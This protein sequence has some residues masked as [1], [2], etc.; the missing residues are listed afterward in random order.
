MTDDASRD[1][2]IIDEVANPWYVRYSPLFIG[3]AVAAGLVAWGR[4]RRKNVSQNPI[5]DRR[6]EYRMEPMP[7]GDRFA[8]T[9][10]DMQW[11]RFLQR[12]HDAARRIDSGSY[13]HEFSRRRVDAIVQFWVALGKPLEPPQ[14]TDEF[15]QRFIEAIGLNILNITWLIE[16]AKESPDRLRHLW[17]VIAVPWLVALSPENQ[18][19]VFALTDSLPPEERWR[20]RWFY[21][22]HVIPI[23]GAEWIQR[24]GSEGKTIDA[25]HHGYLEMPDNLFDAVQLP[26]E[27]FVTTAFSYATQGWK[28][29][30]WEEVHDIE[31]RETH[32]TAD[33]TASAIYHFDKKNY[34]RAIRYLER[35]NG[36][37]RAD[38]V[39][40]AVALATVFGEDWRRWL[41]E[42]RKRG[43]D[44]HDATYWLPEE[45]SPGL[46]QFLKRKMFI[47]CKDTDT[48]KKIPCLGASISDMKLIA[49]NWNNLPPEVQRDTTPRIIGYITSLT[50][51]NVQ[52][53]E[54]AAEAARWGTGQKDFFKIETRWLL[55]LD[56]IASEI[57][58]VGGDNLL[59]NV[60]VA[61][62]T[63]RLFKLDRRDPRGLF[64]GEHTDCCQ[65][66]GME[67]ESCAWFGALNLKSGF[68]V[69]EN[70]VG[71]IVAQSWTWRN[72]DVLVFDNIEG[73]AIQSL[74]TRYQIMALY[75]ELGQRILNA[76][77]SIMEV[78]VGETMDRRPGRSMTTVL[79]TW[80]AANGISVPVIPPPL[81]FLAHSDSAYT[82]AATRQFIVAIRGEG[83]E[84]FEGPA[85]REQLLR[86]LEV[87]IN[88]TE[89]VFF[90]DED[91]RSLLQDMIR[92]SPWI[93]R[94]SV[95]P[96]SEHIGP[97]G[98][99]VGANVYEEKFHVTISLD[100][101]IAASFQVEASGS[102]LDFNLGNFVLGDL[103]IEEAHAALM[104]LFDLDDDLREEVE[105]LLEPDAVQHLLKRSWWGGD[106]DYVVEVS[107]GQR[108]PAE[109][110]HDAE[111]LEDLMRGI[112]ENFHHGRE[113]I[114]VLVRMTDDEVA[115][116]RITGSI[117][118]AE[119]ID[120]GFYVP[121][122]WD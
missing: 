99:M 5:R 122:E 44:V 101:E 91:F 21:E 28:N 86:L 102:F 107:N 81:E 97:W 56:E 35:D 62:D 20:V 42:M 18:R 66:P 8:T 72:G 98:S 49:S 78:R 77:A 11:P 32:L 31:P 50:Y 83:T 4:H 90:Y 38:R 68:Y 37:Q 65:A 85:Y 75:S 57:R 36:L 108:W 103:H 109:N 105:E 9:E 73:P 96:V 95:E 89:S 61:D 7:L 17:Y 117:E 23:G 111:Q 45:P 29:R 76:D 69:V 113:L 94:C 51:D 3:G 6:A 114:C 27:E 60:A 58:L 100:S 59:P 92:Q 116:A 84:F 43:V 30:I 55:G 64:L 82:D 33:L 106:V 26:H 14:Q 52:D 80:D 74:K 1:Q 19:R 12:L 22:G 88:D 71:D 79:W 48:G 104:E 41:S 70:G 24:I 120:D 53:K 118:Y 10:Y 47:V 39:R 16:D 93:V 63:F 54:F 87:A 67:A 115:Q 112:N 121:M 13:H 40:G 15:L 34:L 46:D 2:I 25:Y 119:Q 110:E